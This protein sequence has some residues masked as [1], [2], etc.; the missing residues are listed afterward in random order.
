MKRIVRI[1]WVLVL[2]MG[3][4]VNVR[5]TNSQP[6]NIIGYD[7]Q[8]IVNENNTYQVNETI[9]VF[10]NEPRHG[11]YRKL[12]LKNKV[13]RTDGSSSYNRV[14][15]TD[16]SVD[17]PV[18][19]SRDGDYLTLKIGD[20]EVTIT[21]MHTYHLSYLY[22]IGADPVKENDE[23]Y[24]NLIGN[25]WD[26][27]IDNVTFTVTF[28][29]AFDQRLLGFSSGLEG[30]TDSS[31]VTYRVEGLAVIGNMTSML[32]PYAGLTMRLSLDEGYYVG[33]SSNFDL[34]MVLTLFLPIGFLVVAAY[35]WLRYGKDGQVIETVEF[36]PPSG[37]NSA[38]VGFLYNGFA[39]A[40]DVISL[41]VYL[42]NQGY[43]RIN[44]IELN[45]L[46]G[47]KPSFS[48]TALKPYEGNNP[49]EASFLDG[50]FTKANRL[51]TFVLQDYQHEDPD[52]VTAANLQNTFYKTM[53]EIVTSLNRKENKHKIFEKSSLSRGWPII[54]MVI[55]TFVMIT[56]R[57]VVEYEGVGA[58]IFAMI[59]PGIGF[60][61]LFSMVF[62]KTA[63]PIKIFGL[64]WGM[65]F[66][67]I[68]WLFMVLPALLADPIYL[69][70]YVVGLGCI[71]LMMMFFNLMPKRNTYGLEVL[72]KLRGLKTFLTTAEK[73][74]LEA[75][76]H[77]NPTY[78]YDILPF[79]YVLGVSDVWIKQFESISME[80]PQWYQGHSAFSMVHF[81]SFMHSTMTAANSAM[82]S[83]PSSS[84]SGGG[85]S[86]GGSGGGGG[87]SW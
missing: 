11:I 60:T 31:Q 17:A 79:T 75:L 23:F 27:S 32:P 9:N 1:G 22:N 39:S 16:I 29:K 54:I 48:I 70:T 61:V 72:G 20:P 68:P 64:I 7:V 45:T 52:T 5:A 51:S 47:K 49:L 25:Q 83:S 56:Y 73:E 76:V 21:G 15:I 50:L 8:I 63:W 46:F 13:V 24:F 38:E 36:Y 69:L 18:A 4:M 77:D 55:L 28:P 40:T 10:F 43:I 44:E 26:T 66:G 57:P 65:G 71:G 67:G 19:K 80:P 14:K 74:K 81:G 78:F 30:S 3:L 82:T 62:G 53:N 33:A 6:Y 59:F 87:G 34:L 41:L 37:Y 42:A 85:S 35:W 58:L 2:L 12:P 84:S 86:G